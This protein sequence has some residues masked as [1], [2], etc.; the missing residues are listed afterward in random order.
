MVVVQAIKVAGIV[1]RSAAL[2]NDG[3]GCRRWQEKK[4]I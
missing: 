2:R 3:T 1:E 4:K